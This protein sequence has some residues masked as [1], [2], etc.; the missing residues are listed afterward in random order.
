MFTTAEKINMTGILSETMQVKTQWNSILT[1]KG[2]K[3][4][5]QSLETMSLK[6]NERHFRQ[7]VEIITLISRDINGNTSGRMIPTEY[8]SRKRNE[9]YQKW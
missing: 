4:S 2:K 8:K 3:E 1:T 6:T 7:E 5:R 9:E